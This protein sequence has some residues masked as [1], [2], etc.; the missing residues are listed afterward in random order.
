[1]YIK[2]P[3]ILAR[4]RAYINIKSYDGFTCMTS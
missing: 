3:R 4:L 1:M 2:E